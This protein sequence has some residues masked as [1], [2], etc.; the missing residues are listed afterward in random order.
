MPTPL[1][2]TTVSTEEVTENISK[3]HTVLSAINVRQVIT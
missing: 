2:L 3:L 1:S